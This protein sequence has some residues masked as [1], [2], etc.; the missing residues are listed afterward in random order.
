MAEASER[1]RQLIAA[2][3]TDLGERIETLASRAEQAV[4]LKHHVD[5]HP[6]VTVGIAVATGL[7]VGRLDGSRQRRAPRAVGEGAPAQESAH[8]VVGPWLDKG[9]EVLSTS[10]V[11]ALSGLL[12][13]LIRREPAAPEARPAT[14]KPVPAP[15]AEC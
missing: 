4:S 10:V 1:I 5:A 2:T 3:R 9:V 7:V 14:P 13:D 11:V 12:R 8:P 15:P 6:W